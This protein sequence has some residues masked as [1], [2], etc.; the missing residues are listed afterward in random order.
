M[1]DFS[2][3]HARV[4]RRERKRQDLADRVASIAFDLF[5][6]QGYEAV[7]ME[8]VAGEADVA[9][10][11]LYKYFP[12]KE[13]LLAHQF[14]RD[15]DAGLGPLWQAHQFQRDIDAG[16][17]PLWQVL[18]KQAQFCR[19]NAAPAACVRKVERSATPL[20]SPLLALPVQRLGY[21]TTRK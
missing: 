17:G 12:V 10:G 3:L 16:L 19:A 1:P 14:Q 20:H 4:G 18:E 13:A 7:T 2:D 15:I 9:K 6:S 11:T 8:Q 21:R 5:E